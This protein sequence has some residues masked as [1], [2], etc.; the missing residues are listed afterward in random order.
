MAFCMRQGQEATGGA[1]GCGTPSGCPDYGLHQSWRNNQNVSSV[2]YWASAGEDGNGQYSSARSSGAGGYLLRHRLGALHAIVLSG[3][4]A[5]SAGRSAVAARS[6]GWRSGCRQIGYLSGPHTAGLGASA[7]VA[8][9]AGQAV[10]VDHLQQTGAGVRDVDV[11]GGIHRYTFGLKQ[12]GANGESAAAVARHTSA[13]KGRNGAVRELADPVV[14]TVGDVEVAVGIERQPLGRV[15][16]KRGGGRSVAVV[17]G[18][19]SAGH[20]GDDSIG[21]DAA[22]HVAIGIGEKDVTGAIDGDALGGMDFGGDSPD[23]SRR[24]RRHLQCPQWCELD[25]R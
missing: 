25:R 1:Y 9:R 13:G 24:S 4:I 20:G 3:G 8:R 7:A 19:T 6:I 2:C 16:L 18:R 17:A 12:L 10:G 21:P 23:R 11:A 14:E 22:H 15:E 5:L